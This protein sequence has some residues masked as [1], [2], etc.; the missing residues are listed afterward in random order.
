MAMN[1]KYRS[2][3][4]LQ[5]ILR[6]TSAPL[7][8]KRLHFQGCQSLSLDFCE[9]PYIDTSKLATLVEV[10]KARAASGKVS[11]LTRLQER[12]AL[13]ARRDQAPASFTGEVS[14]MSASVIAE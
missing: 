11:R 9:V 5:W 1:A 4:A 12:P 2:Q 7:L 3:V 13:P 8:L 14:L 10:L 6:A